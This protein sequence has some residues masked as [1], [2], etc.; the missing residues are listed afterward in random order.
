VDLDGNGT[1]LFG[2]PI[3]LLDDVTLG[4]G[5]ANGTLTLSGNIA[6]TNPVQKN[7]AGL[8]VFSG[9]NSFVGLTINAGTVQA[10]HSAALGV[11][12][13]TVLI[14]NTGQLKLSN[15][16]ANNNPIQLEGATAGAVHLL[17][18]SGTNR[19]NGLIGLLGGGYDYGIAA[20]A[21]KLTLAGDI[22]FTD[23]YGSTRNVHLLGDG[24]GWITGSIQNGGNAIVAI[25]KEGSGQWTVT[26]TNS[27]TGATT[28]SAGTLWINGV[29]VSPVTVLGG[30]LGG[31]GV[32][33]NRVTISAGTN[34]PGGPVGIQ[35]VVSNYTVSAGGTLRISVNGTN[36]DT[37]YSQV[38]VRA[39]NSGI[40]TLAG[41]LNVLAPPGLPTN[42]T[43][44]IIDNE[45]TDAVTGT[46]SGLPN[47]ATFFQSGYNW[48]ISYGGG[49]G[50]DVTL[51]TLS[52]S[53]P[54][55]NVS[56]ANSLLLLSWPDWASAYSLHSTTNLTPPSVWSPVTNSPILGGDQ[57]NVVVP[58]SSACSQLFRLMSP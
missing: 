13:G 14:H 22:A 29:S 23:V 25:A 6:G 30:T 40:V 49:T 34:A 1:A 15:G 46:F 51:T 52:V 37:Q 42:T 20:V 17:N 5:S 55:L 35:T 28:V 27:Y 26:G 43:F 54:A 9:S 36:V 47:N 56:A 58:V 50:N 12:A 38:A 53:Q 4:C 39:G 16:M 2:G 8:L 33:S 45:G 21:G 32:I 48:R 19:L 3:T 31:S 10:S 18:A 11:A 41:T 7:G 57:W 24:E 44:V